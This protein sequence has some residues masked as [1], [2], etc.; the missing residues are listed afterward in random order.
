MTMHRKAGFAAL[1]FAALLLLAAPR[2]AY[3][4]A[5]QQA[6]FSI[7]HMMGT[8]AQLAAKQYPDHTPEGNAKREAARQECLRQNHL[9]VTGSPVAAPAH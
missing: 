7:W 4:D 5:Q 9:P 6:N 8:C 2:L 3:A 1:A